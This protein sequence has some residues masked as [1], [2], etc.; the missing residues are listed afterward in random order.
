MLVRDGY[1]S[2]FHEVLGARR[3]AR[4]LSRRAVA[5]MRVRGDDISESH[6]E[7]YEVAYR[8]SHGSQYTHGLSSDEVN[9][10]LS[11]APL[12]VGNAVVGPDVN[13]VQ[14]DD[15]V[16]GDGGKLIDFVEHF[17]LLPIL[18]CVLAGVAQLHMALD[19]AT[20]RALAELVDMSLVVA[21]GEAA[22]ALKIALWNV[23]G[24]HSWR[25]HINDRTADAPSNRREETGLETCDNTNEFE[26]LS[27]TT[28]SGGASSSVRSESDE[29]NAEAEAVV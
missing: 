8:V 15:A 14:V 24:H 1:A 26:H 13:A 29:G 16:W 5:G 21:L 2:L 11:V 12:H 25:M 22:T 18:A 19:N 20:Y 17:T 10:N 23:G 27:D 7:L 28:R 4:F 6:R 9:A 3:P